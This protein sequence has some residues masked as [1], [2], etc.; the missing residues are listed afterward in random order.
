[1]KISVLTLFPELYKTFFETS[2][3]KRA[4]EQGHLTCETLSLFDVCEPKERADGPI[5]GHGPGLL[6]R[7]DVIERAVDHQEQRHGKAF[8]IFFSPQGTQLDQALLRELH[9][10]IV[11]RGGHCMLLPARY[12]GMDA[13]VEEEYAD[14]ILSIG[15]FVLMGGDL[16]AMVFLEG[17]VRFVPGVIGK[18]ESVE[19]DSFSGAFVDYPHYTAPVV[20][21]GKEV[22]EVIRSGNHAMQDLWRH[23]KAAETTVKRHFEWLRSHITSPEDQKLAARFIPPHY[24]ALM[25]TNVLVQRDVEGNSSVT[26]IDIHDIAR[27]ARTFGLK[28]TFIVTPLED[29]QKITTRLLEFWQEGDGVSYNPSRHEAVSEVSLAANVDETIKTIQ[30]KEGQPPILIGTSARQVDSIQNITY[31]DQET[32]WKSGRPV[33]FLFGTAN[34]LGPSI[35]QRCDFI[36]GPV[37]G[38]SRFNHLSV[39]SAA[40]LVFDRWLGIKIKR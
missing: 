13:R 14:I 8:R 23:E 20:W 24:A 1:M 26:S 31:Y 21:H 19:K 33:L 29:Q 37:Y 6:L 25:H 18:G 17:L 4:Q 7:P 36:L 11:D 3:I 27:S 32:V 28:R 40:A 10:K 38:F 2:L 5:F 39:R 16:P 30:L 9:Q 35:L 22:P 34:G 15:D 12:E